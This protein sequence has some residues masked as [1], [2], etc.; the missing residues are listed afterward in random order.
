MT[1]GIEEVAKAEGLT[2]FI[3][4][5]DLDAGRE[6]QY[7]EQLT[8]LRVRGVLITAM[9]T[10]THDW[11]DYVTQGFPCGPRGPGAGGHPRLV[12]G[13]CRRRHRWRARSAT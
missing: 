4:N 3:C 13:G 7:L 10:P 11:L 2:L 1:R 6:D 8:E 5:S 12:H 9:T